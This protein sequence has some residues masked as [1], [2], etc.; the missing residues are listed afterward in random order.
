MMVLFYFWS[1]FRMRMDHHTCMSRHLVACFHATKDTG[2]GGTLRDNMPQTC[3]GT[4]I[5]DFIENHL[6]MTLSVVSI[7]N[8]MENTSK[9]D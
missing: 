1:G 3:L 2:Y 5:D 4:L 7:S 6:D 9:P 8:C